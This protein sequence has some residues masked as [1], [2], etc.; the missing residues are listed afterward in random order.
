MMMEESDIMT[1]GW[2]CEAPPSSQLWHPG[3]E[4]F[5]TLEETNLSHYK[6]NNFVD[7]MSMVFF[8]CSC[9]KLLL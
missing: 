7:E 2:G 9:I 6:Q 4:E 5:V 3:G 1:L 8:G